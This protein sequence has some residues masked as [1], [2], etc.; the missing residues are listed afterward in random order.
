MTDRPILMSAESIVPI[1]GDRKTKTR[2]LS[3]LND[4][5]L[6][7]GR[8]D[9]TSPLG[10]LGYR[11][12]ERTDYNLRPSDRRLFKKQPGLFHWFLGMPY[13]EK[14]INPIPVRCPYGQPGDR[15]W[16]RE[17]WKIA[18]F[19]EGEPMRFQYG[20]DLAEADENDCWDD[21]YE[22]WLER[23]SIQSTD[24]LEKIKWPNKDADGTYSWETGKSPLP[25]QPAIFMPRWASRITLEVLSIEVQ[26]L[27]EISRDE[28][29][30]EGIEA[31]DPYRIQPDLPPGFPAAFRDY[32]DDGNF[33]TADPVASFRSLWDSINAKSGFGWKRNPF[34]WVIEFKRVQP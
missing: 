9:G 1:L 16:V 30:Q 26:R 33:F 6:Y 13:D 10:P 19:M 8:L 12:L 4:V 24:Y 14:E 17:T 27:Q 15:L 34:V 20:A 3:G 2:R 22:E 5:N 29:F 23:V 11:G 32:Q 18:S 28:A 21:K 7:R 25:W 31:V